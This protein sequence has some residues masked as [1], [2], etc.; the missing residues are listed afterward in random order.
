MFFA[1]FQPNLADWNC[2]K[3]STLIVDYNGYFTSV[4][5]AWGWSSDDIPINYGE[6]YNENDSRFSFII[7]PPANF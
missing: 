3:N 2:F 6:T 1:K 5:V 7:E 4:P